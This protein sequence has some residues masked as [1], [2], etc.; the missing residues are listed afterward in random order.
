MQNAQRVSKPVSN[1]GS[2][3]EHM[4]GTPWDT[5]KGMNL[6]GGRPVTIPAD[7]QDMHDLNEELFGEPGE[8]ELS[9]G[10]ALNNNQNGNGYADNGQDQDD[11]ESVEQEGRASTVH[12]TPRQVPQ[13]VRFSRGQTMPPVD[14]SCNCPLSRSSRPGSSSGTERSSTLPARGGTKDHFL[15]AS[16]RFLKTDIRSPMAMPPVRMRLP[17]GPLLIRPS[18]TSSHPPPPGLHRARHHG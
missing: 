13:Q 14:Y 1:Y 11:I 8:S 5:A 12:Q 16:L 10:G 18:S 15:V 9:Y 2:E 7:A 4:A 6:I 17:L 3:F